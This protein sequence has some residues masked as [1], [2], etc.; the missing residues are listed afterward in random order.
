MIEAEA[1]SETLEINSIRIIPQLNFVAFNIDVGLK[2][3]TREKTVVSIYS[4]SDPA[5]WKITIDNLSYILV[6]MDGRGISVRLYNVIVIIGIQLG[7]NPFSN[8]SRNESL[9]TVDSVKK[10][11]PCSFSRDTAQNTL[12]FG[13]SRW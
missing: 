4:M 5:L 10:N 2:D 11:G 12:T 6:K 13:E 3:C 1:I 7:F 9:V 8:M